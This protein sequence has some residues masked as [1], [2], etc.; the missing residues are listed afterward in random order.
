VSSLPGLIS[1]SAG[2]MSGFKEALAAEAHDEAKHL[3]KHL[4]GA[5]T[6]DLGQLFAAACF[7]SSCLIFLFPLMSV[8]DVA[9]DTHFA[10]WFGNYVFWWTLPIPLLF[11]I[12]WI[13]HM[14]RHYPKR[15]AVMI[16]IIV[17][18]VTFFLI[19]MSLKVKSDHLMD[20]IIYDDCGIHSEEIRD[21]DAAAQD[22]EEFF[23]QCNPSGLQITLENCPQYPEWRKKHSRQWEYLKYL[24]NDCGC[25]NFCHSGRRSLWNLEPGGGLGGPQD[26]CSNCVLSVMRTKIQPKAFQLM[27][28]AALVLVV[29]LAWL[30]CMKTALLEIGME[31]REHQWEVDEHTPH[32]RTPHSGRASDI[33]RM[34]KDQIFKSDHTAR[35]DQYNRKDPEAIFVPAPAPPPSARTV[36]TTRP[37]LG[38]TEEDKQATSFRPGTSLSSAP[39]GN[40][41]FAS[42]RSQPAPAPAPSQASRSWLPGSQRMYQS[43]PPRQEQEWADLDGSS[44]S[45]ATVLPAT[46]NITGRL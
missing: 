38:S 40:V 13:Y 46:V 27:A 32:S 28:Y 19:G 44:P 24:Q 37:K 3:H 6:W 17:P 4:L 20:T 21:L 34:L 5:G 35:S 33:A 11:L 2:L 45:T 39:P 9:F 42:I 31:M 29:C 16:S 43:A 1:A 12:V 8:W 18:C 36:S 10:F 22:A 7:V 26:A 15:K 30:R 25:T 23:Q 41:P 14:R